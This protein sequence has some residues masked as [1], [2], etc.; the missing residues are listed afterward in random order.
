MR[1]G[2]WRHGVVGASSRRRNRQRQLLAK[3]SSA[4]LGF[5]RSFSARGAGASV[6]LFRQRQVAT[7]P[8]RALYVGSVGA[9]PAKLPVW[10]AAVQGRS[11]STPPSR[12]GLRRRT[13]RQ[14]V[15]FP[16]TPIRQRC[17]GADVGGSAGRWEHQGQDTRQRPKL[18]TSTGT[19][20]FSCAQFVGAG[21]Q[22]PAPTSWAG[23]ADGASLI[24]PSGTTQAAA[25]VT[26]PIQQARLRQ[27]RPP[28]GRAVARRLARRSGA[29]Q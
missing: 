9:D 22:R 3:V 24:R 17:C 2:S 26:R 14:V 16:T 1:D 20:T 15:D 4:E 18:A 23:H 21:G 28:G 11:A 7:R 5:R 19:A 6:P 10:P 25:P 12:P 27:L 29:S 13:C 8:N